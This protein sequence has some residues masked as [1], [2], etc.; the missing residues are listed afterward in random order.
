MPAITRRDLVRHAATAAPVLLPHLVGHGV[1]IDVDDTTGLIAAVADGAVE[2]SVDRSAWAVIG[3]GAAS[4]DD[5]LVL[6]RLHRTALDHLGVDGRP[7][8]DGLGG[9]EI[10]IPVVA[11]AGSTVEAWTRQVGEAVAAS[12]PDVESRPHAG[13]GRAAGAV[14][15]APG[16]GRAGRRAADVGR[17]RRS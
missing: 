15:A 12:V 8:L 9:I 7:V 16:A 13:R 5:V 10:R 14:L 3:L 6:A 17:A 2:L 11:A 4:F 1:G